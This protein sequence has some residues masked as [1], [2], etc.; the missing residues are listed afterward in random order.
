VIV[1]SA[2]LVVVAVGLLVAG[3]VTSKLLLV[4]VAIATS[5]VALLALG[6]G[7]ILKRD[8]LF[9][10]AKAAEPLQPQPV[11]AQVASA[12][13]AS[14]GLPQ[15]AAA[16]A[17]YGWTA[18]AQPGPPRAGGYLPS[19]QPARIPPA[20]AHVAAAPQA[21]P[22]AGFPEPRPAAP[23]PTVPPAAPE[24][25]A[26][27]LSRARLPDDQPAPAEPP[28]AQAE[29]PAAQTE[30]PAE[31]QPPPAGDQPPP[32]DQPPTERAPADHAQPAAEGQSAGEDLPTGQ[33]RP[34][35]TDDQ[36]AESKQATLA[37]GEE[38][39]QEAVGDEAPRDEAAEDQQQATSQ[40][41]PEGAP[42]AQDEQATA[43]EQQPSLTEPPPAGDA[44]QAESGAAADPAEVDLLR[45]V[46]VVPG[47]PRYHSTQCILIRFMG[48]DDLTRMTL[49]EAR[50][51]GCTP[52]RACQPD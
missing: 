21:P 46:T 9:G 3:V 2:F 47:V 44:A 39:A 32:E 16:P 11:P 24:A 22:A 43:G 31:D 42:S 7:A 27:T 6:L 35:G 12:Q 13:P 38:A 45:Q 49:G 34:G 17:G 10:R 41:E 15:P 40:Q 36:P 25:E 1:F 5:G 18:P 51:A 28:A 29:P 48:E 8:E 4:Y 52:C 23:T 30:P 33:D 14:A 26:A 20:A 19:D 37:A 50:Q